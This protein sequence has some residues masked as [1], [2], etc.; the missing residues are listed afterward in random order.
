MEIEA[1]LRTLA[2]ALAEE[3]KGS[4]KRTSFSH[5][6]EVIVQTPPVWCRAKV[7]DAL[8]G[9]KRD[10]LNKWVCEGKVIAK[11]GEKI[12]LY[13]FADIVATIE[14]LPNKECK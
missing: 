5:N 1:A 3:I 4:L 2:S 10:T 11:K 7:A 6:A 12:V 13:K 9:V 14:S 8:L